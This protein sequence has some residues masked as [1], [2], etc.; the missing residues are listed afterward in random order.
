MARALDEGTAYGLARPSYDASLTAVGPGTPGGAFLRRYWHP[1][2]LAGDATATPRALRV[3]G[4]DLV[5]FRDR[6]GRPGLLYPRCM[7]RGTTLLYGKV[8]DAG[9]RCCYHGWLFDVQ[10]HCLDQPCEP[11]GGLRRERARQ[12]WYPLRERYGLLFAYLGPRERQPPLPRYALL[13]DLADGEQV[14]ADATSIGSGGPAIVPC[15]WLQHFENVMDPLHVPILHG[16]ISGAQF[17]A[18]MAAMPVVDFETTANGVQSVQIRTRDDG[19]TFRRIT[20]VVMPTL[21]VVPNPRVAQYGPAESIGW[22]L[23]IDDTTFRIYVAGR[24]REPGALGRMRSRFN[25][26]TWFELSAAEHRDFP[27]DYEAQVGQGAITAHSEEHL[28]SSDKGVAMLR[29]FLKRQIAAVAAGRDP[30]GLPRD[31]API[32]LAAGNYLVDA[33]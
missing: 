23:P 5:L 19:R 9:I 26:K 31:E 28:V 24:V 15:N 25:G 4:E 16:A 12:P 17:T 27:G 1:V 21:R 10:G 20:E 14:E 18:A 8:E 22:T 29:R 7:H 32:A 2:G 6:A 13:E 3:L 30:A 11:K 33:S